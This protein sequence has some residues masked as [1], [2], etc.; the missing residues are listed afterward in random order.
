M[1]NI[2]DVFGTSRDVTE[3]N[4]ALMAKVSDYGFDCCG[5]LG[6]FPELGR[7]YSFASNYP[8]E[9]ISRYAQQNYHQIDPVVETARRSRLAFCWPMNLQEDEFS[10]P[11]NMFFREASDFHVEHGIAVPVHGPRGEFA[12]LSAVTSQSPRELQQIWRHKG[13]ELQFLGLYYHATR[14]EEFERQVNTLPS[15]HLS[16][17]ERE[18]LLWV[19][20]GKTNWEISEILGTS[21]WTIKAHLAR[22]FQKL[23][24]ASKPHAVAIACV[25]GL[26]NP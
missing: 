11:Q 10:R 16:P 2:L 17:R 24:A 19:A 15:T 21:E 23:Q 5:Y 26:I 13:M 1:L 25:K 3:L 22:I 12:L 8:P 4:D 20:N 9:W 18:V 7:Q 14:A 6:F